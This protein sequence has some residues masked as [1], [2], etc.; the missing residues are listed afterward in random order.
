MYIK[1]VADLRNK[2]TVL[3]NSLKTEKKFS[4]QLQSQVTFERNKSSVAIKAVTRAIDA[5]QDGLIR[6]KAEQG[7]NECKLK[8]A[9]DWYTKNEQFEAQILNPVRAKQTVLRLN[10]ESLEKISLTLVNSL[11]AILNCCSTAARKIE[12]QNKLIRKEVM[13]ASNKALDGKSFPKNFTNCS[14]VPDQNHLNASLPSKI[15]DISSNSTSIRRSKRLPINTPKSQRNV[16]FKSPRSDLLEK[17]LTELDEVNSIEKIEITIPVSQEPNTQDIPVLTDVQLPTQSS[18]SQFCDSDKMLDFS[19]FNISQEE[20]VIKTE[21]ISPVKAD[22]FLIKSE[23]LD[24]SNKA[25]PSRYSDDSSEVSLKK[26]INLEKPDEFQ[27]I[28]APSPHRPIFRYNYETCVSEEISFAEFQRKA[29]HDTVQNRLF[30]QA[31]PN[32]DEIT[33]KEWNEYLGTRSDSD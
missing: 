14:Y 33:E 16:H 13:V 3:D 20:V 11:E 12:T 2:N 17:E 15:H 27:N 25:G 8:K 23:P 30:S 32:F 21:K 9:E 10:N 24:N 29:S 5:T 26:M 31:D 7:V 22:S 19:L 1:E 6:V 18:T 4:T 28:S